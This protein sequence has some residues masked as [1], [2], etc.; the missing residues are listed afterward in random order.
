MEGA[1]E[2]TG[3]IYL[4]EGLWVAGG[5]VEQGDKSSGRKS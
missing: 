4:R 1:D 3:Q 5:E 2:G